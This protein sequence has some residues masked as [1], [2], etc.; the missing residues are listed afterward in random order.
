MHTNSKLEGWTQPA[1]ELHSRWH[2]IVVQSAESLKLNSRGSFTLSIHLNIGTIYDKK[3]IASFQKKNQAEY[4]LNV[5]GLK[6]CW[7]TKGIYMGDIFA[8]W[9]DNS[10]ECD[11]KNVGT[12]KQLYHCFKWR[13][14]IASLPL[15]W[16]TVLCTTSPAEVIK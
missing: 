14:Y 8:D 4:L 15:C 2:V 7:G 12:L 13:T 16:S 1:T 6:A 5:K 11:K 9:G 10:S 3:Q